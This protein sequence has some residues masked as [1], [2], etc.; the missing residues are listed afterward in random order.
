MKNGK[1]LI[2]EEE[3]LDLIKD[4]MTIAIG[5]F[6]T[7]HHPMSIL[8]GIAKRKIKNLM[9]IGSLSASFEVDILI[10]CGCVKKLA[11]A[12]VGAESVAPIGP[13]FKSAMEN[14]KLELW[15]CDEIILA[16][17]L[18][19][20]A[21][22]LPFFPVRGGLGTDLPV[23]NPDLKEFTDPIKKEKL[24][25]V[26]A[27]R[28]D[29]AITHASQADERGNVQYSGNSYLDVLMSRAADVTITSVEKI[30][31]TEFIRKDPFKT[32]YR[33]D[34]VLKAP[35]GSHPFSSHGFYRED[36]QFLGEYGLL[37]YAATKGED[38]GWIEFKEKYIDKPREHFEYLEQVGIRRLF[39]LDEF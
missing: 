26:P 5:G 4:D 13:F 21:F 25:A 28:I 34:Y 27:K 9:I 8:R 24:L 33:A 3:A 35:F 39:S 15:E 20:S 14:G 38:S 29:I 10:G 6:I 7:S 19:A 31:P 2:S 18:Q 22:D 11:A 12:Y 37:A 32:A 1:T 36:E 30:V 16:A 17:Q 23:L